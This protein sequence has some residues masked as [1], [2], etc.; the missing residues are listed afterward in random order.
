ML[1]F[2]RDNAQGIALGI[3]LYL[4]V[5][6]LSYNRASLPLKLFYLVLFNCFVFHASGNHSEIDWVCFDC[7]AVLADTFHAFSPLILM[8]KTMYPTLVLALFY[9]YLEMKDQDQKFENNQNVKKEIAKDLPSSMIFTTAISGYS[10]VANMGVLCA[11]FEDF[12]RFDL[13]ARVANFMV[14]NTG[15]ILGAALSVFFV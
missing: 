2:G 3:A 11:A 8:I 5:F 4:E 14:P 10:M 13:G 15:Y 7:A 1:V 9:R 12:E 6:R